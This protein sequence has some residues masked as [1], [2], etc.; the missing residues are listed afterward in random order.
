MGEVYEAFDRET[1]ETIAVKTLVRADGDTIARFKREFRAL[2]STSHPNLVSLRELVRDGEHWFLTMELVQGKHFLEYVRGDVAKLRATL[3]QLVQAIRVLHSGGLIHRDIKPSN[4]MVTN[5]GRVVLLDFGLVTT[6]DPAR[7]SIAGRAIGTVEY[8]APEQAVGR[9]VT[10]AADWYS[11]G[12]ILYEALTGDVPHSG[13]ALEIMI[14]KQ[15]KEPPPVQEVAPTA[16][17]DLAQLTNAL[18]AIEPSRRPSEADIARRLGLDDSP[19]RDTPVSRSSGGVFIGRERELAQLD[20]SFKRS[21]QEPILHLVVGESGI[22]KSELVHRYAQRVF[23]DDPTLVILN[24]RCYERESVPY[25]ALDGVADGLADFLAELPREARIELL[26]EASSLLARL[27]P[28][29]MRI[30]AIASA[31]L[32]QAPAFDP[33]EQRR[34]MFRAFRELLVKIARKRRVII[35]VDDL[36]WADAD[37]FLLLREILGGGDAPN[38]LVLA[39]AREVD[40]PDTMAISQIAEELIDV[41]VVRTD[42]GRLTEAESRALAERLVP[43]LARRIDV[44]RIA[45]EAGGHPMFLAEILRHIDSLGDGTPTATLDDALTSRVALLGAEPRGLLE[46]VCI[47]GVPL[48]LDVASTA[49]RLDGSALARA[50]ASLRV[51]SLAREL[52]RGRGLGLALEPF[53]DRVRESVARR[54]PAGQL[55]ELHARLAM[56][57]ETNGAQGN[58]QLLLRHFRLAELPEQ[59]ARYAEEAANRSLDA[60]AFEQA[61][62]LWRTALTIKERD[63][64]DR[65]RLLLRLG[66]ALISAGHGAEA[67][68]AYLEASEGAD[69]ATRLLCH[70]HV[71]E[72]LLISGRVERGVDSLE[73]LFHEIGV[74]VPATPRAAL[75]SLLRHRA[76][77]RLRGLKFKERDR[78][79]I[80]DAEILK[81]DVMQTASKGLSIVDSIR[82]ADFQARGLLL[83]LNTGSRSHIVQALSLEGAYQSTQGNQKRAQALFK[84]AEEV[85][86]DPM[87]L[88]M[89]GLIKGSYA[90]AAYF[91]GD[92]K[93]AVRDLPTALA[94]VRR[95]PGA[96]WEVASSK[97]F[98]LMASRLVGDYVAMRH[99]Y[100]EYLA[101]ARQRGDRYVESS[102]RR[103]CVPMWL[104]DDDAVA[105]ARE[106]ELATWVPPS[107]R[108]HVQH[109]HELIARGEIALYTGEPADEAALQDGIA[110]LSS[111]LLLRIQTVRTQFD[112]LLGRLALARN[113]ANKQVE[114]HAR[115]LAK[116]AHPVGLVWAATLRAGVALRAPDKARAESLVGAAE[117]AASGAGMTLLACALRYR[118]AEL[119]SDSATRTAA[120]DEM[121]KLGVRTPHKMTGLLVP[122][123]R[124]TDRR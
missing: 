43:T 65:R 11:V 13:H 114:Q 116:T 60:Y 90:T 19:R 73:A 74:D 40:A 23:E 47:A 118:L 10:E 48:S 98:Y 99:V 108:Y 54:I 117:S 94:I 6:L 9:N 88:Y 104:A 85:A 2:Q 75:F 107:N 61:A 31:P 71:A 34:R 62:R 120:I 56:A 121:T 101:E 3:P 15:Q 5:D 25:K 58:P 109:F 84:R 21:Q 111:S 14:A 80:S 18:L 28:V 59:A 110:Q 91:S 72:Q 53:H 82:G 49:C 39:T 97:L 112:F 77:L 16:P 92:V 44:A 37:S 38:V 52:R 76:L 70:R 8:M 24:G 29:F 102:M 4:V 57:L 123:A 46:L 42:L 105:A 36:Q 51:A 30:E 96:N 100:R 115:A 7:Q 1:A 55:R 27:F 35:L 103:I 106:L 78:S 68:E 33:Q 63:P 119:R 95:I 17:A 93:T 12:V 64:A 83:A 87:D 32:T 69:R 124:A 26:P 22:G 122:T 86:G 20:A 89:E 67:A 45:R 113:A 79:E 50:I 41:S 81:L 66:E